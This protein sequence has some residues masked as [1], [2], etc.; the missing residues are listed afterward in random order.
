MLHTIPLQSLLYWLAKPKGPNL[1]EAPDTVEP[2]NLKALAIAVTGR[3]LYGKELPLVEVGLVYKPSYLPTIPFSAIYMHLNEWQSAVSNEESEDRLE[4]SCLLFV[5]ISERSDTLPVAVQHPILLDLASKETVVDSQEPVSPL[6]LRGFKLHTICTQP[7]GGNT[8][9]HI[10][11]PHLLGELTSSMLVCDVENFPRDLMQ[12]P[13][14]EIDLHTPAQDLWNI[15][16]DSV[17]T[18]KLEES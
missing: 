17:F 15:A 2:F 16:S 10:A 1:V 13:K 3:M 18:S 5:S 7:P 12:C 9:Y 4:E 6:S 8:V 14:V 11:F